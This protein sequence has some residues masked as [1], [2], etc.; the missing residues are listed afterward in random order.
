MSK[1][2]KVIIVF[3]SIALVC[4]IGAG[5]VLGVYFNG[6]RDFVRF[7]DILGNATEIDESAQL[8]LDDIDALDIE[9]VSG[10]VVFVESDNARVTLKGRI[11]IKN[12]LDSYLAVYEEGSKL[13]AVFELERQ[14]PFNFVNADIEMTIYLPKENMLDLNVDNTSGSIEMDDMN[15]DDIT[16]KS[17]SGNAVITNVTA[18]NV[19]YS[20]TSGNTTIS[21][22]QF[23]SLSVNCSSGTVK[24]Y[25][26]VADTKVV[27]TSGS[28]VVDGIDGA[29]DVRAAS[30]NVTVTAAKVEIEP[31]TIRITSGNCKLYLYE[32]SAFD[33]EAKV[34][35]GNINFDMPV[36]ISGNQNRKEVNGT[37]NG[38]GVTVDLKSTSGNVTISTID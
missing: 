30:G 1:T 16:I 24:I 26:T 7:S 22:S 23:D 5:I 14:Q 27:C 36:Q 9:C 8:S 10:N 37:V 31:I 32:G 34:T 20:L 21:S 4:L 18:S 19:D 12:P 6:S 3:S 25:D 15:F 17:S 13:R 29:V 33:L 2:A 28:V 38:G 35:S 11:W